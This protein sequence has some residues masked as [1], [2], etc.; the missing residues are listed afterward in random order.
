MINDV[1]Y[2]LLYTR[3]LKEIINIYHSKKS[4]VFSNKSNTFVSFIIVFSSD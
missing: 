1:K 3:E 2:N 4:I